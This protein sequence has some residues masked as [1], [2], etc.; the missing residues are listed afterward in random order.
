M[1]LLW[2]RLVLAYLIIGAIISLAQ[3]VWGSVAG[4]P[5]ALVWT[6][7]LAGTAELLWWWLFAPV[8]APTS[9]ETTLGVGRPSLIE[10]VAAN[11]MLQQKVDSLISRDLKTQSHLSALYEQVEDLDHES[12]Q[13]LQRARD[14]IDRRFSGELTRMSRAYRV[15]RLCGAL[16]LLF[17]LFLGTLANFIN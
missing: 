4:G 12:S 7:S 5:T 15:L 2:R 17:G 11:A 8:I 3:N 16:A 13:R 14:E 10:S 6:G 1:R 9:V